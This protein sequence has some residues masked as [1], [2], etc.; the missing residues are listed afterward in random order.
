LG[1]SNLPCA[2]AA[3]HIKA[4]ERL[5]WTVARVTGSHH[6]LTK[7]GNRA[8]LSIPGHKGRDVPRNLLARALTL[9]SITEAEYLNAFR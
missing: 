9:A 7:P 4:L 2:G 3:A 6:I 1:A 5:G 8:T